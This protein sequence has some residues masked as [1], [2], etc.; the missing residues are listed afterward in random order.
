MRHG[1]LVE[2][3]HGGLL[4]YRHPQKGRQY[5][6]G[7]D[8]AE[9]V[10]GGDYSAAEVV[11]METLEQ[12]AEWRCHM[13]PR[14][15]GYACA[16]LGFY[17]NSGPM[18]IES[19][20]SPYGLEAFNA[21]DSYGYPALWVQRT[22]DMLEQRFITKRGWRREQGSTAV[23]LGRIRTALTEGA[24]IRSEALLDELAACKLSY[25]GPK[26]EEKFGVPGGKI[27]RGEHDDR[28]IA[29]GL[30]VLVRD[31]AYQKGEIVVPKRRPEDLADMY[32]ERQAEEE[33]LGPEPDAPFTP[34]DY[35]DGN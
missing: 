15:W 6:I 11:D 8:T 33:T 12:V 20:P 23:L 7:V 3:P 31:D 35:W 28:A 27:V 10:R 2:N 19:H 25:G 26:D 18:A 17:Y 32:W 22:Y 9:G 4:I 13:D 21:A 5:S 16:R 30:A 29:Y 1:T 34:Y 24:V 14:L